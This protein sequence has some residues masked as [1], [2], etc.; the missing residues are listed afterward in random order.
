MVQHGKIAWTELLTSDP[1][2]AKAFFT[3]TLGWTFKAF[4]LSTPYWIIMAGDIIV[5]GLGPLES[6]DVVTSTSY[7]ISFIEVDD[8]DRRYTRALE[9]GARTV[10]APHDVSNVGRVAVFYDPTNALVGWTQSADSE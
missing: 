7:W 4:D 6:G 8:I 2:T 3:D 9:L 10:R 1:E 5:G